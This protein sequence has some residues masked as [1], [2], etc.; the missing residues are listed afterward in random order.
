MI[1]TLTFKP[2]DTETQIFFDTKAVDIPAKL[3]ALGVASATYY[4]QTGEAMVNYTQE[5][6]DH[7][8]SRIGDY[9]MDSGAGYSMSQVNDMNFAGETLIG[10]DSKDRVVRLRQ[11]STELTDI[12]FND[13]GDIASFTEKLNIGGVTTMKAYNV[14]YNNDKTI[15]IKEI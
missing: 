6:T 8:L 4:N 15:E 7:M 2:F 14:V 13:E 5:V 9:I 11:G 3:N 10:L 1:P 12:T